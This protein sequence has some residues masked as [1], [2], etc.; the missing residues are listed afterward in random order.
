MAY[1]KKKILENFIEHWISIAAL[2][3]LNSK[4]KNFVTKTRPKTNK[5]TKKLL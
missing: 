5:Q 3:F 1:N 4:K 2:A